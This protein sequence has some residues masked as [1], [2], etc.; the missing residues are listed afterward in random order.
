MS[1]ETEANR[2]A[3]VLKH[4]G[5]GATLSAAAAG[6][7]LLHYS[8]C[9]LILPELPDNCGCNDNTADVKILEF[10]RFAELRC[11]SKLQK[12]CTG[13]EETQSRNQKGKDVN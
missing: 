5:M 11:S 13:H 12:D 3:Y 9:S 2:Q 6:A 4:C 7:I 10:D 8:E 1:E